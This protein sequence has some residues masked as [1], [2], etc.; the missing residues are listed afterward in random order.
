MT[1]PFFSLFTSCLIISCFRLFMKDRQIN[2][3]W[4]LKKDRS[5][6]SSLL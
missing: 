5:L 3:S 4:Q 6:R 2:S 1:H